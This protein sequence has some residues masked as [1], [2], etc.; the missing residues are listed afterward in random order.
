MS[1]ASSI[2][3]T[4]DE[5]VAFR[6][7]VSV[8]TMAHQLQGMLPKM[9]AGTRARLVVS[10]N[11]PDSD[12]YFDDSKMGLGPGTITPDD[13][14][15]HP[16]YF[17]VD[18][19]D[20]F[21]EQYDLE[22]QGIFKLTV[23]GT[24][25][26]AEDATYRVQIADPDDDDVYTLGQ[27]T[28]NA[29][30]A[31]GETSIDHLDDV[32][33]LLEDHIETSDTGE[34]TVLIAS[35]SYDAS[36]GITTYKVEIASADD[37]SADRV[38]WYKNDELVSTSADGDVINADSGNVLEDGDNRIAVRFDYD[39]YEDYYHGTEQ[40]HSAGDSWTIIAGAQQFK[41]KKG[42][43]D[44]SSGI[45]FDPP[46]GSLITSG[47]GPVGILATSMG[48]QHLHE[49][50]YVQLPSQ[51]GY[52]DGSDPNIEQNIWEFGVTS[53]KVEQAITAMQEALGKIEVLPDHRAE[54]RDFGQPKFHKD[55]DIATVEQQQIAAIELN[56]VSKIGTVPYVGADRQLYMSTNGKKVNYSGAD[57]GFIPD[58]L[59]NLTMSTD[60]YGF[61]LWYGYDT[62]DDGVADAD[63][64]TDEQLVI[65]TLADMFPDITVDSTK[66]EILEVL[67]AAGYTNETDW[68]ETRTWVASPLAE[69]K[70]VLRYGF[71]PAIGKKSYDGKVGPYFTIY[72]LHPK[73]KTY[74]NNH[75]W[76]NFG[77][78]T[79]LDLTRYDD[80]DPK[81][82]LSNP[83][84]VDVSGRELV[85]I[86]MGDSMT[87]TVDA[88][89]EVYNVDVLH[90]LSA[91][92]AK[93]TDGNL[94]TAA[95]ADPFGVGPDGWTNDDGETL[96]S[97]AGVGFVPDYDSSDPA[98]GILD[99][100]GQDSSGTEFWTKDAG[101]TLT[102]SIIIGWD[103]DATIGIIP[104][105]SVNLVGNV[106][107]D[108]VTGEDA[109]KIEADWMTL[110]GYARHYLDENE[111]MTREGYAAMEDL[112][113]GKHFTLYDYEFAGFFIWFDVDD[114]GLTIPSGAYTASAAGR[115]TIADT[116]YTHDPDETDDDTVTI[117]K[118]RSQFQE[119]RLRLSRS[120]KAKD[121]AAKLIERINREITT[122]WLSPY[123]H[124]CIGVDTRAMYK[125]L[126]DDNDDTAVQIELRQSGNVFEPDFG[127]A[128]LNNEVPDAFQ[129][130]LRTSGQLAYNDYVVDDSIT[131]E[132]VVV[133]VGS[134]KK[135]VRV[136]KFIKLF[137]STAYHY[138]LSGTSHPEWV[139]EDHKW[140]SNDGG[141]TLVQFVPASPPEFPM[142]EVDD[143][144]VCVGDEWVTSPG[145]PI[146]P[147]DW[148]TIS[149]PE[150]AELGGYLPYA[151]VDAYKPHIIWFNVDGIS[152]N[153]GATATD[154]TNRY[155]DLWSYDVGD[156]DAADLGDAYDNGR[157]LEIR[158]SSRAI[159]RNVA[160]QIKTG[161]NLSTQFQI[162]F[163][164]STPG[165]QEHIRIQ[166]R[167]PGP[168]LD[169]G[170][171][172][173][174]SVDVCNSPAAYEIQLAG[175]PAV[176]LDRD[177]VADSMLFS[178]EDSSVIAQRFNATKRVVEHYA[179]YDINCV[180]EQ[181]D[182]YLFDYST[183]EEW[184]DT[185]GF[186]HP[187]G[188]VE[189]SNYEW[190][191]ELV[192][193]PQAVNSASEKLWTTEYASDVRKTAT[194]AGYL[195]NF[196]SMDG[197]DDGTHDRMT[198]DASGR[199][200]WIKNDPDSVGN[201]LAGA[202]PLTAHSIGRSDSTMEDETVVLIPDYI[203][204]PVDEDEWMS[205]EEYSSVPA[206]S[207]VVSNAAYVFLPHPELNYYIW[208][209]VADLSADPGDDGKL[210]NLMGL[211]DYTTDPVTYADVTKIG[212]AVRVPVASYDNAGTVA[213]KLVARINGTCYDVG[214]KYAKIG[215][216]DSDGDSI[217]D[218]FTYQ[219][220]IAGNINHHFYA[221]ISSEDSSMVRIYSRQSGL[222]SH[223]VLDENESIAPTIFPITTA[224][225]E[226]TF[227]V[228]DDGDPEYFVDIESIV[229]G[230]IYPP[231]MDVGK[232]DVDTGLNAEV[233]EEPYTPTQP[234]VTKVLTKFI[235]YEDMMSI[236]RGYREIQEDGTE[237]AKDGPVAYIQDDIGTLI[238]P[239]IMANVSM[240]DPDQYDG[241]IE[242]LEIRSRASR[243]S[244]DGY[245]VA[246]E[247]KG[248]IMTDAAEDSRK[249]SNP[250]SQFIEPAY[251]IED[252]LHP[253]EMVIGNR[254]DPYED[255]IEHMAS[256]PAA[257]SF[258]RTPV[259]GGVGTNDMTITGS[260][261]GTTGVSAVFYYIKVSDVGS[262]VD[263]VIYFDK[264][265]WKKDDEDWSDAIE[266]DDTGYIEKE[267]IL[268]FGNLGGLQAIPSLSTANPSGPDALYSS[269]QELLIPDSALSMDLAIHCRGDI[270]QQ[271]E[272]YRIEWYDE[273]ETKWRAIAD[274]SNVEIDGAGLTTDD[275]R[276]YSP[277]IELGTDSTSYDATWEDYTRFNDPYHPTY[278]TD[279]RTG[280]SITPHGVKGWNGV[281]D[282][283]PSATPP[284][285]YYTSD[286]YTEYTKMKFRVMTSAFVDSDSPY[287]NSVKLI[288][289]FKTR[290]AQLE[291]DQGLTA[292][293]E[294]SFGH[295]AGD[296]WYFEA[297]AKSHEDN[298]GSAVLPGY[299]TWQEAKISPFTESAEKEAEV[300]DLNDP[301]R[302]E[303][304]AT[305]SL[306]FNFASSVLVE[307][308]NYIGS[309][310][311]QAFTLV[312]T[313]GTSSRF[314]F[315]NDGELEN[316]GETLIPLLRPESY[317]LRFPASDAT[318]QR[319]ATNGRLLWTDGVEADPFTSGGTDDDGSTPHSAFTGVAP[320]YVA[321]NSGEDGKEADWVAE[322]KFTAVYATPG[323]ISLGLETVS[324]YA[325]KY[326]IITNQLEKPYQTEEE[327]EKA[328]ILNTVIGRRYA[329][330]F[331]VVSLD[332]DG[333]ETPIL[334]STEPSAGVTDQGRWTTNYGETLK[335]P[336]IPTTVASGYGTDY[337]G[338]VP[339]YDSD[340][341]G[342]FDKMVTTLSYIIPGGGPGGEDLLVGG[343]KLWTY[344]GTTVTTAVVAGYTGF[345]D[346]LV[347][348]AS[349]TCIEGDTVV[350]TWTEEE[351]A[352]ANGYYEMPLSEKEWHE[353]AMA[354]TLTDSSLAY[355]PTDELQ[356]PYDDYIDMVP[357]L[358]EVKVR[359]TDS[360]LRMV[361]KLTRTL[362]QYRNTNQSKV[363]SIRYSK[364]PEYEDLWDLF[365]TNQDGD[366]DDGYPIDAP[367]DPT[368]VVADY[369]PERLV[370]ID[371]TWFNTYAVDPVSSPN[372]TAAAAGWQPGYH[373]IRIESLNPGY[374]IV[375]DYSGTA[376]QGWE[377][378]FENIDPGPAA[379]RDFQLTQGTE[380]SGGYKSFQTLL[381]DTS[382]I[383]NNSILGI[384]SS[385]A[386]DEQLGTK[387]IGLFDHTFV[388]GKTLLDTTPYRFIDGRAGLLLY[389]N[390]TGKEGNTVIQ[391]H[392]YND[393][394]AGNIVVQDFH[395][396]YNA[397]PYVSD[398]I[399][400]MNM[401]TENMKP[402]R[403]KSSTSGLVFENNP[404]GTDSVAFGG[405][406]K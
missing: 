354:C 205:L 167:D 374:H 285:A 179:I 202:L 129:A 243:N 46:E 356:Q 280:Y 184:T 397:G 62:D 223:V 382:D 18:D 95:E 41:W 1:V 136:G 28:F 143:V 402:N 227:T 185:E 106:I 104:A 327:T 320:T 164:V 11:A 384:T 195:P 405:W 137:N 207:H 381:S 368:W 287:K 169:S 174:D 98:D 87:E 32:S 100:I 181:K 258:T 388:T 34:E 221:E 314:E 350:S 138:S 155:A 343:D 147:P 111:W 26:G 154:G 406:K 301:V 355:G 332:A 52:A 404:C 200:I 93:R 64:G 298:V 194:Q 216:I 208:F 173:I 14:Q 131:S 142:P 293:F 71:L 146:D 70:W 296:T 73:C 235:P 43:F 31:V 192:G 247:V 188:K 8:V 204:Y 166:Q 345:F 401:S 82:Q 176:L 3:G 122:S 290:A 119:I 163:M 318:I 92:D 121:V 334:F 2:S 126:P 39:G 270:N 233:S 383:V 219:A 306:V 278:N 229:P 209:D 36:Q 33:V 316:D 342:V 118:S 58:D 250:I 198:I 13:P 360:I 24:Y 20:K 253:G 252:E 56:I 236:D 66:S 272:Y 371:T 51:L 22:D 294:N 315:D 325:G 91:E 107:L 238:Y 78:T 59:D 308:E 96:R 251:M 277:N 19:E 259:F 61:K 330:W 94:G 113:H 299:L 246:H 329:V 85:D 231:E 212:G 49:G 230:T 133:D 199:K 364:P 65:F 302:A 256:S 389:Q 362:R 307:E 162:P 264:M 241:A 399:V 353:S 265:K 86:T 390:N 44:D 130:Y 80:R 109:P 89:Y 203:E 60:L 5:A 97:A 232:P 218:T 338:Y 108:D 161:I 369:D 210:D 321:Y 165:N 178:F 81:P 297:I 263:D 124:F 276:G 134:A 57:I 148:T 279:S 305:G 63:A 328:G 333:K 249:R 7:G 326:F 281:T 151:L 16:V 12:V 182:G 284:T 220:I 84:M 160:H 201:P 101:V 54:Q 269:T 50:I 372:V 53:K 391:F 140:W 222:V 168:I 386:Y 324:D 322:Y 310:N 394:I 191:N 213:E 377:P 6:Q 23:T 337:T 312:D 240:K 245:F 74:R 375:R 244:P 215:G 189:K 105:M 331:N 88:L 387:D 349:T 141:V 158:L 228:I 117:N 114:R 260:Y 102:S 370:K 376:A 120:D 76:Y 313:F 123:H 323:E 47:S 171:E 311:A 351:W 193:I 398:M 127:N 27:P 341:D 274:Y 156:S 197:I 149:E 267:T 357:Q 190:G 196:D 35:S 10:G 157:I 237:I 361:R 268:T 239:I 359:D 69:A 17:F 103:P 336:G 79:T 135:V 144:C 37:G 400:T 395:N 319:R 271:N 339:D 172:Q 15:I 180:A 393:E 77:N 217:L 380:D 75:V 153:P 262:L 214:K 363:F 29:T 335:S 283:D 392:H 286:R 344:D 68:A 254:F 226:M 340:G 365:D 289:T 186:S 90:E 266:L 116:V 225:D 177:F 367:A 366:P 128:S 273:V 257:S 347:D 4:I 38:V 72:D 110:H 48:L 187:G 295:S 234:G 55:F 132:G 25:D 378:E 352:A 358:I 317:Y 396:G 21:V 67:N 152:K 385:L 139:D 373:T 275:G 282:L 211:A 261:I 170:G 45:T 206:F 112:L 242:P 150:W 99:K 255:G 379:V 346:E 40:K 292:V 288:F 224:N 125:A 83:C 309:L 42:Q 300:I 403:H 183:V 175:T 30:L 9:S 303:Y 304:I 291:L 115:P 348:D 159:D 248:M 145:I